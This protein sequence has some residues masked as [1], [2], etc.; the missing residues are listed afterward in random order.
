MATPT[1]PSDTTSPATPPP[2]GGR[3]LPVA[4]GVGVLLAVLYVGSLLLNDVVFLV[5]VQV[6]IAIAMLELDAAFAKHK[7][8][9]PTPV[10]ILAM[11]VMFFGALFGGGD[12][13]I[14]GLILALIGGFVATMFSVT[15]GQAVARMSAFSLMVLWV[16]FMAS[17][18]GL[19]L[20][21]PDGYWY[22]LAG[23]ALTVTHDIGAY[24]FGSQFGRHKLAPAI[25]PKKSWEGFIGA[26]VTTC[27]MAAFV[28]A[29]VVPG[30]DLVA[31]LVLAVAVV[32]A[33]TL[34]DLAES[35]LKRDLGVKD[36]GRI[37]PGH[38]GVMD[39]IDALLFSLPATHLVLLLFDI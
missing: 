12:W 22:V 24:A 34:G 10:A 28:T 30:V 1:D 18:L 16:P 13:Q 8:P 23:T 20:A 32:V 4:I 6:N 31:A 39:R 36:L 7:N 5:F 38:G 14:V 29:R 21:R 26:L 25:S 2:R 33:A 35:I 9:P 3:N 27:L 37:F 15:S 17:S 11:P 19:L